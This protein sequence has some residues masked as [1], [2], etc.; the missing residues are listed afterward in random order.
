[1]EPPSGNARQQASV[2][3]TNQAEALRSVQDEILD[4]ANARGYP[5]AAA[6][7]LRLVIEEAV[8]N[9]FKHGNRGDTHAGVDVEWNVTNDRITITVEDRG[10]GFDPTNVPDPT[11]DDRLEI[12]SGRGLLLIRAYMTDVD[13]NDRGNRIT[14]I[15]DNPNG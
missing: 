13:F 12:P 6:F 11:A 10:Q 9:A 5:D 2:R 14:M 1:M 4:A 3:I 8:T 7:A 15:Y